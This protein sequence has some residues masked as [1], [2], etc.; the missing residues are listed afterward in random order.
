[1]PTSVNFK[2]SNCKQMFLSP[3]MNC[4]LCQAYITMTDYDEYNMGNPS[5]GGLEGFEGRIGER[6]VA[7]RKAP[8]G[9]ASPSSPMEIGGEVN[10]LA[11][12]YNV[13]ANVLIKRG[14]KRKR[15]TT[16]RRRPWFGNFDFRGARSAPGVASGTLMR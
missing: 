2:L 7:G 16:F 10:N 13:S 4:Q 15:A 12:N 8:R 3:I 6:G 14:V 5:G 9:R 1:M 11:V